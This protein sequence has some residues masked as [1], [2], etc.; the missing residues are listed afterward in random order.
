METSEYILCS[1]FGIDLLNARDNDCFP[2][3]VLDFLHVGLLVAVPDGTIKYM[4]PA[5]ARMFDIDPETGVNSNICN[6]FP[7]SR[8]L[9]VMA[10][11]QPDV[12]MK[13]SYKG[14][15]A[16]ISR[17]P[18]LENGLVI[19]GLVEAYFRDISELSLLI[20]QLNRLE[21]KVRY[22][23]RKTQGLPRAEYTFADIIGGSPALAALKQ[24]AIR[25]ARSELPILIQGESG[26]GKELVAHSI[27]AASP[28]CNEIFVRLNCAAIPQEL[29]ESEL[30]GFEEGA[31]TGAL[32]GG[33]VGK[34]ELADQGTILLDEVGEIPL[35][36]QAKLLRV[37][38][39][40]EIQKIG[41]ATPLF[42]DFR[43]IASTN[44]DL[45][46]AVA[47]GAFRED[48]YHRLSMLRLEVPPLRARP[49]D[50]AP[51]GRA[52]LDDM[53]REMHRP[54]LTITDEVRR[55]AMAYDWPGNIREMKNVFAFAVLSLEEGAG[56]IALRHLPPYVIEKA[57][58]RQ[59]EGLLRPGSLMD[60]RDSAERNALVSALS[61]ARHNKSQAARLLGISRNEL[62]KKL[63][64]HGLHAKGE[65]PPQA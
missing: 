38:E 21:R 44:K 43:L 19:G 39:N 45:S 50:I 24:Q 36:T 48:L 63:V 16:L 2:K 11:G 26:V 15:D 3:R 41:K 37:I 31:F 27:H 54:R 52:L 13:F 1:R 23:E 59:V 20:H 34:F 12:G 51:I 30:F 5:F 28:R 53:S 6:Y 32:R 25:F 60:Q 29:I 33:K 14:Q 40:K 57:G 4:N 47:E 10:S 65:Q 8:L 46:R 58:R 49:E 9:T 7:G 62:Y 55:I 22:Y 61:Q 18:L 64:K 17:Y 35:A 56:E 42:S